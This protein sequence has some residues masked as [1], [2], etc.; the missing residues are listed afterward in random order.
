MLTYCSDSELERIEKESP[1]DTV[2]WIDSYIKGKQDL[3]KFI[4][5]SLGCPYDDNNWDGF[6]DAIS[7]LYWIPE[8]KAVRLLHFSM[9]ALS[10]KELETYIEILIRSDDFLT[11][12]PDGVGLNRLF[13]YFHDSLRIDVENIRN[14]M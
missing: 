7:D 6:Y 1:N 10:E 13:V 9:P 4:E 5:Q 11:N 2:I 8:G 14:S 3:I 12:L